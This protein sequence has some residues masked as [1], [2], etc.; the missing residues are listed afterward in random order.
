[1]KL[2]PGE[3]NLGNMYERSLE[4]V[5]ARGIGILPQSLAE[6]L[7]E[8]RRDEVVKGALGPIADEFIDLKSREWSAYH[9][10]V[11]PWEIDQHRAPDPGV[12]SVAVLEQGCIGSGGTGRNTAII[13]C[14]YLAPEGARFY[15]ASLELWQDLSRA[16]DFNL[17]YSERGHFTLAHSN[18]S[19]RTQRWRAEVNKTLGIDSEVVGPEFIKKCVREMDLTC[20]GHQ[21]PIVGALYHPP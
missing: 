1:R 13:R 3:P 17:F 15:Q 14:N 7:D 16:L 8:L 18:A 12:R 19:L 6:A 10:Q 4:E 2:D 11:G 20:G 21:P 5:R 9:R